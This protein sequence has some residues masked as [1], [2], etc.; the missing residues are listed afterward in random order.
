MGD[1][2]RSIIRGVSKNLWTHFKTVTLLG[3]GMGMARVGAQGGCVFDTSVVC[4]D[5]G[6]VGD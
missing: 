6:D 3:E 2:I 5:W 1:T 4:G